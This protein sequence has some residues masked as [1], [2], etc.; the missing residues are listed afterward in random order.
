MAPVTTTI[1][2]MEEL[3]I[4]PTPKAL[5]LVNGS[6]ISSNLLPDLPTDKVRSIFHPKIGNGMPLKW[7]NIIMIFGIH[8]W[9]L[10]S[11]FVIRYTWPI[12][13]WGKYILFHF[14]S[15]KNNRLWFIHTQ[16]G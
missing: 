15:I 4:K 14:I 2:E 10:H 13:L 3:P 12:F 5:T 7:G 8:L 1:T 9:A 11:A 16:N 6:T